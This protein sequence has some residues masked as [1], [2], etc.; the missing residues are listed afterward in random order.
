[1]GTAEIGLRLFYPAER[2]P[3]LKVFFPDESAPLIEIACPDGISDAA[4]LPDAVVPRHPFMNRSCL[5][6]QRPDRAV[7]ACTRGSLP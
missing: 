7:R 5:R 2:S 4:A 3:L 6:G 1:M